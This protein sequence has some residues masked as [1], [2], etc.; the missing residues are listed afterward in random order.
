MTVRAEGL[1]GL[2]AGQAPDRVLRWHSRHS[3]AGEVVT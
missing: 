1:D 3:M 2:A